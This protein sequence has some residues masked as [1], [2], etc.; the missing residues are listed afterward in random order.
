MFDNPGEKQMK[1]ERKKRSLFSNITSTL[2]FKMFLSFCISIHSLIAVLSFY[3]QIT[4]LFIFNIGSVIV[5]IACCFLLKR[6]PNLVFYIGYIEII[7]HSFVCVLLIGNGFGFSMYFITL[8]PMAYNLLYS[9]RTN[10]YLK[11]ATFLAILSFL[12]FACCYTISNFNA[13]LY[14]S[15]SLN[16]YRLP[17]YI[18]NMLVVF[19]ALLIFSILFIVE[20]E[21]VYNRIYSQN[22]E[23]DSLANRDP[24]TGLYNRRTMTEHVIQ[25]YEESKNSLLPFSLIL[26]DIDNFKLFNDTYG[27]DC[28]DIVLKAVSEQL[29]SLT[30]GHDFLCRWGGEEFLI[31]LKNIDVNMA[32]IIAERIRIRISKTDIKYNKLSLRVTMTFG[33]AGSGETDDYE[34]LFKL[35]DERLY[36]GKNTGKNCI[37]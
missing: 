25:M 4:P 16:S 18:A 23:L 33:I 1:A 31:L 28:G 37:I 30:R 2:K 5:Y 29:T 27:H 15:D 24:L 11:K 9:T 3:N 6:R 19:S 8:V 12:L 35:A 13:P 32:R 10:H 26:C 34:S 7:L 17:V 21:H 14:T 22:R 20:T 36:K